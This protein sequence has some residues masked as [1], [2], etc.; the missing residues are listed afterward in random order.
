M[1]KQFIYFAGV[2]FLMTAAVLAATAQENTS[3]LNN[4]ALNNTTLNVSS[5][6]TQ[7]A[8]AIE[9]IN[10]TSNETMIAAPQANLNETSN[11]TLN[12]TD[13]NETV[14]AETEIVP[15]Q[16]ETV[17]VMNETNETVPALN[18]TVPALNITVPE[19]VTLKAEPANIASATAMVSQPEVTQLGAPSNSVFVIG[20]GLKS[21]EATQIGGNG[22]SQAYEVGSPAKSVKDLSSIA[23]DTSNVI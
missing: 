11:E 10:A 12:Q 19:N 6:Q 17:P 1:R 13:M 5:N 9:P 21:G 15:A 4:T 18:V 3:S 8:T 22:Q 14:P 2:L 23:F 16:N 7:N 20:G